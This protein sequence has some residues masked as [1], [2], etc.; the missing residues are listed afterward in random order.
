EKI[1]YRYRPLHFASNPFNW[2]YIK[3]IEGISVLRWFRLTLFKTSFRIP[4]WT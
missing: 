1:R 3:L 2:F 4:I